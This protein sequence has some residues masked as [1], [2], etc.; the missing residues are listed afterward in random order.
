MF[1]NTNLWKRIFVCSMS[2]VV[3]AHTVTFF[4]FN[5]SSRR[6]EALQVMCEITSDTVDSVTK[7][8]FDEVKSYLKI[9]NTPQNK[10]WIETLDGTLVM[11]SSIAGFEWEQRRGFPAEQFKDSSAS[12]VETR[13]PDAEFIGTM[14]MRLEG[15]EVVL[16]LVFDKF[17]PF[18]LQRLFME[19]FIA[20]V[21]IG[22][23]LAVWASKKISFPLNQLRDDVLK[24]AAGN[25]TMR[26]ET[27]GEDEIAELA[28]A[29]N[30]MADDLSKKITSGQELIAGISHELR[31][32]ISRINLSAAIVE[33]ELVRE[34][35]D[36]TETPNTATVRLKH[37]Q[38]IQRETAR[39]DSLIGSSLLSCKLDLQENLEFFPVDISSLCA[40]M[41]EK[42]SVV[43]EN[44]KLAFEAS[45][46]PGLWI[47]GDEQYICTLVENLL[48][49]AFKYTAK[50][51]R[52]RFTLVACDN[53]VALH[54][55]NSH[56]QM[57]EEWL[58]A[59]FSPFCRGTIATGDGEGVGF[60]LYLVKKISSLHQ[61]HVH[62]GNTEG[63]VYFKV[64]LALD[65]ETMNM[66]KDR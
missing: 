40:E 50:E 64:T 44:R 2:L 48:D 46:Q 58:R 10:L 22:G 20:V 57:P 24:I 17:Q 35:H 3:I 33:E 16:F 42:Y 15:R 56:E 43:M 13:L 6:Y 61:G 4:I 60:G 63:G 66:E 19:G 34:Y 62:A 14:P 36:M 26:I 37:M 39:L 9:F 18:P 12:I 30:R 23:L 32:P 47:L 41:M 38:S 54:I 53:T 51:G 27:K 25:L 59:I 29:I 11:G 52:V 7:G 45:I 28:V 21:I 31:S 49:N 1:G 5:L 65:R 55:E 8:S